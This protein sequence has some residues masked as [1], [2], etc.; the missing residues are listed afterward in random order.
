MFANNRRHLQSQPGSQAAN[1]IGSYLLPIACWQS[2]GCSP[3]RHARQVRPPV[4]Q[5]RPLWTLREL[6]DPELYTMNQY[7][8]EL[9]LFYYAL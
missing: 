4:M 9:K 3:G 1:T 7:S 5:M 2:S 6:A 8:V